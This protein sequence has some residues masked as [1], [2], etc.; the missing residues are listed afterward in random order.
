MK[1]DKRPLMDVKEQHGST[2][3]KPVAASATS[4]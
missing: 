4:F 2:A 3:K 1:K